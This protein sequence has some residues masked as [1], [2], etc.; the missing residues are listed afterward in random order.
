MGTRKRVAGTFHSEQEAIHAIKGLKHQGYRETDILVVAKD[1]NNTLQLGTETNVMIEAGTPAVSS[2][3]G[4]MMDSFLTMMTGGM[5]STTQAGGLTSKLV[6]MGIQ[7]FTAKQCEMDVREGKILVLIDVDE[8]QTIPS[9][10]TV[11]ESPYETEGHRSVQLREEQLNVRKERVQTGEVQL[12][13]EIVEELRTVQVP[14]MREEV[15]IERR[16]VI[17]GQYD[18]SPLTENEIIRIPIMEER[19]EVT[20][21]PVVVEEVI[22]GKRKIQEIKEV[23]DTVRK[24]EAQIE[25]SELPA[26]PELADSE[27]YQNMDNHVDQS[28][29]EVAAAIASDAPKEEKVKL[30]PNKKQEAQL[31]VTTSPVIKEIEEIEKVTAPVNNQ[32]PESQIKDTDITTSEKGKNNEK[33]TNKQKK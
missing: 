20:K 31:K 17:D 27:I 30:S 29:Q 14:V 15:Y 33:S 7:N 10:T 22:I 21:R 11:R 18:A 16:Q 26:V 24:E 32:K 4:V 25:Q 23:Q 9:Y 3:A 28:Y 5:I 6:R 13:K 8:T 1:S 19:I 12:R 2:L